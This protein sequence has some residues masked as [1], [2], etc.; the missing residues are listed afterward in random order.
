MEPNNET[1]VIPFLKECYH[2]KA[3]KGHIIKITKFDSLIA[4][5]TY[6]LKNSITVCHLK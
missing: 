5:F 1:N 4:V 2:P 6:L 3:K